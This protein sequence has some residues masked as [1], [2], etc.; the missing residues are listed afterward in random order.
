VRKITT[1]TSIFFKA[2]IV[3]LI[4]ALFVSL[5][6]ILLN[7]GY[8]IGDLW[9]FLLWS[10]PFAFCVGGLKLFVSKLLKLG[11]RSIKWVIIVLLGV[12]AGVLWTVAVSSVLG[13]WFAAF[14]FPVVFSWIG[15]G[16]SG[17]TVSGIDESIKTMKQTT[18][19]ILI[20]STLCLAANIL[21][22]PISLW[23]LE[24]QQLEIIFVEWIPS[25]APLFFE[26]LKFGER[27][28]GINQEELEVLKAAGLSGKLK[29]VSGS[30]TGKGKP[31][32]VVIVAEHQIS[33]SV[34]LDQPKNTS[35]IYVQRGNS[36]RS[37]PEKFPT[38]GRAIELWV[39]KHGR[40]RYWVENADGSR[41]GGTAFSGWPR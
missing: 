32:R 17:L 6:T 31:W 15:G 11:H 8:G 12:G 27:I 23:I 14:S 18:L 25:S 33:E 26:P 4:T 39:D 34:R 7:A 36:W 35:V 21:A 16:I 22:K 2:A 41:S 28:Y 5:T 1:S 38:I 19:S 10:L 3:A 40:I 30:I 37:Y 20:I 13:E 29:Y 9:A 24:D